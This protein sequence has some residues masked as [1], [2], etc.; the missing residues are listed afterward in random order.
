MM[1][2]FFCNMLV[3]KEFDEIKEFC[4]DFNVGVGLNRDEVDMVK[5]I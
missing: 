3:Y 5:N 2:D 1:G 4:G